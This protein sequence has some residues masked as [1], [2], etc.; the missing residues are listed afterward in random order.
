MDEL[1]SLRA[2]KKLIESKHYPNVEGISIGYRFRGGKRTKEIVV[3]VYVSKKL[4]ESE[5][6]SEHVIPK[7][8]SIL[9]PDH[10]E[11]TYYEVKTDV[12]QS[13]FSALALIDKEGPV[14]PGYSIS[15]PDV[16]AGT[17]G[18]F[19]ERLSQIC[20]VSNAHV[21]SNTNKGKIGDPIY[22]PGT[23][24]GGTEE[25]TVA[26]LAATIPIEMIESE[27]P[28]ANFCVN[29]LNFL[30]RIFWSK[31]RIPAPIREVYNRVDCACARMADRIEINRNIYKIGEPVGIEQ[32]TLGMEV[33]K[34]GRTSE[35]TEGEIIAIEASIRVT[36]SQGTALFD[37]Q[38]VSNIPSAGG[39]SGSAVLTPDNNLV[40][41][42]FAGGEGV[43]IMNPIEDVF[44]ALGIN[45][46]GQDKIK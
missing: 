2:A 44:Y 20:L 14:K 46:P 33:R 26:H 27:C 1:E 41:L 23:A 25:N 28:I 34:S 35:Y 12:V 13:R 4:P 22:Y 37:G 29:G 24:D 18:F 36:Y 42:L 7:T 31:S 11:D 17:L 43:T 5:L 10:Y 6:F 19:A 8:I 40:G 3:V 38:I 45:I 39:D 21:I 15:H 32:A 16:T 9:E 30:A